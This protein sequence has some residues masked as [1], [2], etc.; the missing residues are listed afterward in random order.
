MTTPEAA[1]IA[2]PV[3]GDAPLTVHF[4]NESQ[5]EISDYHWDFGDGSTSHEPHVQHVFENDGMYTVTLVVSGPGGRDQTQTTVHVLNAS[6]AVLPDLRSGAA[7]STLLRILS[8]A[9]ARAVLEA[10]TPDLGLAEIRPFPFLAIVGQMEMRIA[11]ML[12]MI[13]PAVGGVL[14]IGPRGTGKTTAV[15]SIGGILPDVEVSDCEEGALPEDLKSENARYLYPDCWEK[16]Q[17]GKPISHY[18]PVRLVELPLNARLEDVVGGINERV[19]VQ[20]NKV[21]IER[22]ILARADNNLLY[23][24]EVN[25]LD[26]TI[27]DAILDAAAQGS[28]TVRRG[29]MSGTYRARFVLIGSMNPEEGRLRPQI[30]DRFG[31]RVNVRGLTSI[32]ERLEVYK[33]VRAYRTQPHAFIKQWEL[34]TAETRDE[35]ILAR[36][37]LKETLLSDD[38]INVGLALVQKLDID[39]HRAEY[40][41]FEAARAYA[42]ADNRTLATPQDIRAVAP[43]ALRQR[44][45]EFMNQFFENQAI[46]DEQIRRVMDEIS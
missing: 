31:L 37:R 13:N 35:V 44:R 2:N 11:L 5:G 32:E 46:E 42:A 7:Q 10:E 12:A 45:S 6:E 8:Q 36:A 1:F 39:S 20:Q 43:L 15:R 22:G 23:I 9:G 40:T 18:E 14:L 17:A 29:A 28:Y 38:A 4:S 30:L 27:V 25:L 41:M 33:R 24:D 34:S 21:R 3:S 26:D 19:A 16:L